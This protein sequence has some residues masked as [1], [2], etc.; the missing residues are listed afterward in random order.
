MRVSVAIPVY[1]EEEILP[2]LLRRL[3]AVL[4]GIP[5]GPHEMVLVDDGSTD[6]TPEILR[7]EAGRD[8]RL[9]VVIF[10]RNFGHQAAVTAALDH[11]TGDVTVVMDGDLQ[12]APE[13][14][15]DFL[16]KYSEGYDVVYARRTRRKEVWWLRFCYYAFYRLITMLSDTRL[17]LDA[18]DFGLMSRRVV[19]EIRAMPEHHRYLR[20]LRTWV[21]FRQV[22]IPIERAERYAGQPKYSALKLL[23][24]ATDGIFS[25]S[26]VPLR[27]ATMLGAATMSVAM[28]YAL[29]SL[30]IKLVQGQPPKGF[31]ALII[32]IIF[33]A[34]VQLFFMGIIGEYV[35][36]LF[37]ASKARPNYIV[38]ERFGGVRSGIAV[39]MPSQAAVRSYRD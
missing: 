23:K 5:G 24:L 1:N 32:A 33:L 12:D 31:T 8:P 18:G 7:D 22:D 20:G 16:D 4:A 34:G 37:E 21:G 9:I 29:Y 17:P 11:V 14:I 38:A 13:N 2:E 6:R 3:R 26:V 30:W 27:F 39:E 15:P 35:G 36:R 10:S 25:F 28:V 19:N